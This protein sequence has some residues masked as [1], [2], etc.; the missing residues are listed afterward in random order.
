MCWCRLLLV[1]TD[2]SLFGFFLQ[3]CVNDDLVA[4]HFARYKEAEGSSP[5]DSDNEVSLNAECIPVEFVGPTFVARPKLPFGEVSPHVEPGGIHMCGRQS[6]MQHFVCLVG[7]VECECPVLVW[8]PVIG[9]RGVRLW[10]FMCSDNQ[11]WVSPF[12]L[13]FQVLLVVIL[14]LKR[15]AK[16][17]AQF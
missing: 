13:P 17:Q 5:D 12:C 8:I 9:T 15:H 1:D 14:L 4:K 7:C 10:L 3:I 11:K 2:Q 6:Y 16:G